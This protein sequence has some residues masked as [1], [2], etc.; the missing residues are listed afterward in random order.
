MKNEK[1]ESIIVF[2]VENSKAN[3][4]LPGLPTP[5][6]PR[7]FFPAWIVYS[8]D[9]DRAFGLTQVS[10]Y[11]SKDVR[12][13]L[14]SKYSPQARSTSAGDRMMKI[15]GKS[16]YEVYHCGKFSF[17]KLERDSIGTRSSDVTACFSQ[18][19]SRETTMINTMKY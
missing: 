10:E 6:F 4:D 8:G 15:M 18:W 2:Q 12:N 7:D 11:T 13:G 3:Y 16:T 19:L 1:K 9:L 14:L 5:E 17:N